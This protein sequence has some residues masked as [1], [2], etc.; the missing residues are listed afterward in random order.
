MECSVGLGDF[1][2]SVKSSSLTYT[3][4]YQVLICKC[5]SKRQRV[6]AL[7]LPN[8]HLQGTISPSL[9]NLSFLSVLNLENNL[10]NGGIPYELGH[11]PRL[12][13]IDIQNNQLQGSI[14]SSLFQHRRV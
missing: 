10:F 1:E 3:D 7:A 12:R 2:V 14:P 13:V 11:L 8:L 5:N 4:D 6:V 9:A